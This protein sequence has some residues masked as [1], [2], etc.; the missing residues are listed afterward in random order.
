MLRTWL[1]LLAIALA[2]GIF[3]PQLGVLTLIALALF[4]VTG[5]LWSSAYPFGRRRG[6]RR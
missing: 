2:V 1:I 6:G 4:G 3:A 5:L